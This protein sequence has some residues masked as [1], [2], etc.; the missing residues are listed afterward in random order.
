MMGKKKENEVDNDEERDRERE[1]RGGVIKVLESE[2]D[3]KRRDK[4]E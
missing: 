4:E 3:K 1:K 2:K